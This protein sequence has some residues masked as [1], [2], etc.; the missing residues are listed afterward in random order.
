MFRYLLW[1]IPLCMLLTP[2]VIVRVIFFSAIDRWFVSR[3]EHD[4]T[5]R[6]CV[7][8]IRKLERMI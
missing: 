3:R 5:D 6:V 2:V 4:R 1:I 7:A 8:L